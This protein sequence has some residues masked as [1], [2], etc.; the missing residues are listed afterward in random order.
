MHY[1][2][3]T[4]SL[5]WLCMIHLFEYFFMT[6]KEGERRVKETSKLI[7]TLCSGYQSHTSTGIYNGFCTNQ[8]C[9]RQSKGWW[10]LPPNIHAPP[11]PHP[12]PTFLLFYLKKKVKFCLVPKNW[13][14]GTSAYLFKRYTLKN[15]IHLLLTFKTNLHHNHLNISTFNIECHAEKGIRNSHVLIS[16]RFIYGRLVWLTWE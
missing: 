7:C 6:G 9:G 16:L 4:F 12:P 3:M 15:L 13:F 14:T 11:P 1:R 2:H 5:V 10:I 8:F